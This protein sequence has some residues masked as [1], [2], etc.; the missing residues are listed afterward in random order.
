MMTGLGPALA[1][2]FAAEGYSITGVDVNATLARQTQAD[3][4]ARG[5]QIHFLQANLS[6]SADLDRLASELIAGPAIDLLIHNAGINCVGSFADSDLVAQ[7][8]VPDVNLAA[9]LQLRS[10][11]LARLFGVDCSWPRPSPKLRSGIS[12]S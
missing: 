11:A 3:L 9:P 7:Q 2:A 12:V 10:C 1:E 8:R 6:Q 5:L 4:A